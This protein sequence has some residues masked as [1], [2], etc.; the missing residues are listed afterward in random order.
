METVMSV[1]KIVQA[2]K[3]AV[4]NLSVDGSESSELLETLKDELSMTIDRWSQAALE[5][6]TFEGADV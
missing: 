2:T 1:M 6:V 3:A 5:A 4:S